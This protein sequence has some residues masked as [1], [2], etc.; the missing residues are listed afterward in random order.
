MITIKNIPNVFEPKHQ[1]VQKVS[2]QTGLTLEKCLRHSEWDVK[3]C[4]VSVD[5]NLI[6][7]L[8]ILLKDGQEVFVSPKVEGPVIAGAV[9]GFFGALTGASSLFLYNA[10]VFAGKVLAVAS[11]ALSIY[12]VF[13]K[14]RKPSFSI[15]EGLDESSPT[16][17]W[18]GMITQ[19]GVGQPIPLVYGE[20]QVSGHVI[21]FYTDTDGD[22]HYLNLLLLLSQGEVESIDSIKINDQPA[23]NF[24]SITLDKRYGSD[25]QSVIPNFD[26]QHNVQTVNVTLP[27]NNSHVYTTVD[28]DV[29]GFDLIFNFTSI[30]EQ[31]DSGN[32]KA[33]E[34]SYTVEYKLNSAGTWTSLGTQTVNY[35]SQSPI[36]RIFSKRG[37]SAEKY[38]IRVTKVSADADIAD[39][40][41][42]DLVW[43]QTDE[44]KTDDLVYNNR[45]L[46]GIRALATEQ[47]S[48]SAPDVKCIVKGRKVSVPKVM[49]GGQ[50]TGW[51][52]YYWD[53]NTEQ[54]KLLS[55][56]TV[57]SWD[58]TSYVHRYSAN[59][60]WCIK[61]LLTN[62]RYGLGDFT[63]YED[64]DET[65]FLEMSRYC[66]EKVSDL[67]G[68]YCKRYRLDI[69]I[70]SETAVV[71]LLNQLSAVFRGLIYFSEGKIK[72]TIDKPADLDSEIAQQFGMGNIIKE[73][74]GN[75]IEDVSIQRTSVKESPNQI[76]VQYLNKDNSYKNEILKI[77]DEELQPSDPIRNMDVRLFVTDTRQA[78][79]LGKYALLAGKHLKEVITFTGNIQALHCEAGDLIAFSHD[80][81]Q[82]GFSG[83]AVAGTSNSIT[84]DRS[85]VI[86]EGK[87]YE[88]Q[89]FYADSSYETKTITNSA[90]TYTVLNASGSFSQVPQHFTTKYSFGETGISTKPYRIVSLERDGLDRFR[91]TALEYNA[92][93][94]DEEGLVLPDFSYSVL[95]FDIPDVS[96]LTL[97]ERLFLSLIHI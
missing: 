95:N 53:S 8:D 82:I 84:L 41:F 45:A 27:Q 30:F 6:Q 68:G 77:Q 33:W 61:D 63:S 32:I 62:R 52:D 88:I 14:P 39:G 29:E 58:G 49:N 2:Y 69:V 67:N 73:S 47:L 9:A 83:V 64:I 57:L 72:M 4:H 56:D 17:N 74:G 1:E 22:K 80:V 70:D 91:I 31:E 20:H 35:K 36:K 78:L 43:F 75:S 89:V 18:D 51:E 94:Y 10:I 44:I 96:N 5:G 76:T 86:E 65:L 11:L 16:Y 23:E 46:L 92:G 25:S 59:P 42:G 90:G 81:P 40:T 34:M 28:N 66:E 79:T 7:D 87:S 3:D 13:Q 21:N 93:I 71:D 50:E 54:Y 12:S 15:G 48:G 19:Y 37:L 24:D 60:V 38:D 26:D 55:D 97:S 85:I